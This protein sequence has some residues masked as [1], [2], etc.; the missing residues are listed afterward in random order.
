MAGLPAVS[1][2]ALNAVGMVYRSGPSVR[3]EIGAVRSQYL[4]AVP[5]PTWLRQEPPYGSKEHRYFVW[6]ANGR[7]RV[8]VLDESKGTGRG[9]DRLFVDRNGDGILALGEQV[10]GRRQQSM[11]VF[12][13]VQVSLPFGKKVQAYHFLA[14]C[15][16]QDRRYPYVVLESAC[17]YVGR[18]R[19][20][21]QSYKVALVDNN[22]NGAFND[23]GRS[24]YEGDRL[25]IDLNGDGKFPTGGPDNPE[26]FPLSK[27]LQ[28]QDRYLK[29]EVAPEGSRLKVSQ[30]QLKFGQVRSKAGAFQITLSSADGLLRIKSANGWA[31]VPARKYT[32][33]RAVLTQKDRRG[34]R[35]EL[36]S[37]SSR[38]N[39]TVQVV[40]DRA[41]ELK[42][43]GP[44]K[45]RISAH[46]SGRHVNFSLRLADA[47]GLDVS[48]ITVDGR[49]P[50]AP[51]LRIKRSNGQEVGRY[52]FHYG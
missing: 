26:S 9:F 12:G 32:L 11:T 49:R 23:F 29:L 15:Y 7:P 25:L 34:R 6:S 51:R 20:G 41:T 52:D 33:L 44:L 2:E 45:A 16:A 50:P 13:P 21:G 39:P 43:G 4:A 31:R 35:W 38:T 18:L 30:P 47:A 22:S 46:V 40:A 10:S 14:R 17:Y 24:P 8:L 42:L 48:G 28:V 5:K 1:A 27:L 36:Q 37:A 19:L 3:N